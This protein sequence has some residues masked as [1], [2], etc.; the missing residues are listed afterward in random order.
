MKAFHDFAEPKS[1]RYWRGFWDGVLWGGFA[2]VAW[3]LL[4]WAYFP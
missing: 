1:D 3:A 4:L 2:V